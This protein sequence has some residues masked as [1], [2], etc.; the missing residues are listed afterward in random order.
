[1]SVSPVNSCCA[2]DLS[3]QETQ[4][5]SGSQVDEAA[6]RQLGLLDSEGNVVASAATPS[7]SPAP[8]ETA[9]G[10]GPSLPTRRRGCTAKATCCES[11][12]PKTRAGTATRDS[13]AIPIPCVEWLRDFHTEKEAE[14]RLAAQAGSASQPRYR[15]EGGWMET[16]GRR[17]LHTF[18]P[19]G[20]LATGRPPL[21]TWST[22][23]RASGCAPPSPC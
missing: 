14:Y 18:W 2:A 15:S 8:S 13:C 12:D 1:M 6:R 5:P 16:L 9:R 21:S 10:G 3:V 19:R 22:S 23:S 20:K 17:I 4:D 7:A 11:V